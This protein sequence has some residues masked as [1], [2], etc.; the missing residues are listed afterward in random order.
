MGHDFFCA[1]TCEGQGKIPLNSLA[2]LC[3]CSMVCAL[4]IQII[5]CVGLI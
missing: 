2:F 3:L 4:D 1:L 5:V